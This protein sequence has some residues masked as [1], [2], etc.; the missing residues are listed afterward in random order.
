MLLTALIFSPLVLIVLSALVVPARQMKYAAL[1]TAVANLALAI[2]CAAAFP[3]TPDPGANN[4]VEIFGTP[5]QSE[6]ANSLRHHFQW[7]LLES[8]EISY[9]VGVDHLSMLMVLLT[10]ALGVF[11]V[12]CSFTGITFREKE[13]Y[14]HLLVLQTGILG[15]F[16]ALDFLV[17]YI[18][19]ELMMIPLY[20]LIG[21]WG[22]KNRI[23]ATLK[24][25]I[26]T[27][28]GS[29]MMLLAILWLYYNGIQT[30]SY[31]KLIFALQ[32]NQ[33]LLTE[34]DLES[35]GLV[36]SNPALRY[37]MFPYLGFL[38][39]FIIKVP[40]WPLH[41]W[42][43]DAHTE[44]PTAGSV[45]LAGVLLKTGVYGILRFCIPIFP[46]AAV[47]SAPIMIW[48]AVIAIIYGAMTAMVQT[49]MKRL[50]AY[51]SVSH[52][53]FIVLGVYSFNGPG[54]SGAVLQMINH[55]ISTGGLFLA[56]GMIYERRHTRLMSEFG[57]LAHRLPVFAAL[58]MM[59]VLSSVG[60][61]GLNGFAG[62]LPILIG[63][64]NAEPIKLAA[65]DPGT[66]SHWLGQQNFTW[67]VA[68]LS[69]TGVIFGAV[70]LLIMYQ[71]VFYG[72][73]D[74]QENKELIDLN[75]REWGQLGALSIA[76][77]V[78]GIFPQ[79]LLKPISHST[80]KTLAVVAGPLGLNK[81]PNEVIPFQLEGDH[82]D[83]PRG[84]EPRGEEHA[85]VE[86]H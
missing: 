63:S 77:V 32:Q 57:G 10:S 62:E 15:T 41:T 42:L 4:W 70:Y 26:Y 31:E 35:K 86:A 84:E 49:D 7:P 51:S 16:C 27:L 13:F 14:I 59:M 75:F 55:G 78:I 60:L 25:V 72:P 17:F 68:C 20:F 43:P 76:A 8:F 28:V 74:K 79:I 58:T 23:Y 2:A 69:I 85:T 54:L 24:F 37:A 82:G 50:V 3:W 61:P 40:L 21:I 67:V 52:M 19:W 44:A 80:N 36:L 39:A 38:L 81:T 9:T 22:S 34:L 65:M 66:W 12:L 71:K 56:V 11:A 5:V 29:L 45:I 6:F 73:L 18:A 83:E 1:A 46:E 64:M 53:G 33:H 48:L 47:A 30:Y